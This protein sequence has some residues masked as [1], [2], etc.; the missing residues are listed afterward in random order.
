MYLCFIFK[1]YISKNMADY[2]DVDSPDVREWKELIMSH[3]CNYMLE[4][5]NKTI[6]RLL[7]NKVDPNTRD[8]QGS[9]LL[10]VLCYTPYDTK[11][12]KLLLKYGAD[13]NIQADNGKTSLMMTCC[14][15]NTNN[16]IRAK[17]LL[18][19]NAD[20][21]IQDGIGNTSLIYVLQDHIIENDPER[22]KV[23]L[24]YEMDPNNTKIIKL[25]L[26]NGADPNIQNKYGETSLITACHHYCYENMKLLLEYDADPNIRDN[27]NRNTLM[28]LD[29]FSNNNSK[30]EK[31]L[32][33][34]GADPNI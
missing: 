30:I 33:K 26:E 9:T 34:Y 31:L 11:I 8:D 18:E 15:S 5:D 32:L 10:K 7:K 23:L 22:I 12:I 6:K 29:F 2:R 28:T 3:Q 17:L 27:Y 24:K 4:I 14:N 13:P 20:P 1:I 21:N 16:S 19:Y 25:L